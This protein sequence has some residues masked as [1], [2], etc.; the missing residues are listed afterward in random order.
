ME[1]LSLSL[2]DHISPNIIIVFDPLFRRV[3]FERA[4]RLQTAATPS[5]LNRKGIKGLGVSV[6]DTA[7]SVD[8]VRAIGAFHNSSLERSITGRNRIM[9]RGF[10]DEFEGLCAEYA[11]RRK[12]T[13][14]K[15]SL[16]Y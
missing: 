4:D 7:E 11:H 1:N 8:V 2:F 16:N 3:R 5:V 6:T 10:K 15:A 13:P 14:L 9:G 12:K